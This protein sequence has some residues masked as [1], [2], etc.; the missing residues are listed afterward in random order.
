MKLVTFKVRMRQRFKF[1]VDMLRYDH[2]WPA[3][4]QD[5]VAM[6]TAVKSSKD[7]VEMYVAEN[8]HFIVLNGH[9]CTPERW[10]S[11]GWEVLDLRKI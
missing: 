6:T 10:Q 2:C 8:I 4:E 3:S 7:W 9:G 1:P 11:F 5:S